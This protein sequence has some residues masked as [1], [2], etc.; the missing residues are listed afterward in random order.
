MLFRSGRP[1]YPSRS[2]AEAEVAEWVG[3]ARER[4]IQAVLCL[5]DD[6]QLAYYT[7]V[8]GGLLDYYRQAGFVVLHHPVEDHQKPAVP[9][10]VL[11]KAHADFLA[12][13]KPVLVHCSAG[14]DRTGAV[15]DYLLQQERFHGRAV[16]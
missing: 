2:V 6:Q 8:P 10:A 7:E 16:S 3:R 5:L 14:C 1:G 4:G 12:A 11:T 13:T 9:S 15:V